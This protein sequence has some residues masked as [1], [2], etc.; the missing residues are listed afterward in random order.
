MIAFA[1]WCRDVADSAELRRA[2][3]PRHLSR[4]EDLAA[5]GRLILAGPLPAGDQMRGSLVVARFQSRAEAE[6]WA[7]TDPY[8]EAGVYASVE[9]EQFR[10]VLPAPPAIL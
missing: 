2:A 10:Q 1:F 3:R 9:I 8:I 5:E 4:L 6:A 7:A